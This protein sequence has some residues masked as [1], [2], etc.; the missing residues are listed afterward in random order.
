MSATLRRLSYYEGAAA[1]APDGAEARAVA[2]RGV[3]GAGLGVDGAAVRRMR[4]ATGADVSHAREHTGPA[5]AEAC[6]A[7]GVKAYAIGEQVAYGSPNPPAH[8]R[9]HEL[10]HVAQNAGGVHG[11]GAGR[12]DLEANADAVANAALGGQ[13]ANVVQAKGDLALFTENAADLGPDA[14]AT[15]S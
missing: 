1:L 4:S 6:G 10:A 2:T 15:G 5:A 11:Y 9:Y 3:S 12:A 14:T 8:V 13:R 7:L